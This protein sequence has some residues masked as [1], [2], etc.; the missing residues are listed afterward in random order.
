MTR[1]ADNLLSFV[2]DGYVLAVV[3]KYTF[4]AKL[5]VGVGRNQTDTNYTVDEAM[6]MSARRWLC[7]IEKRRSWR[8]GEHI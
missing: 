6:M 8:S 1:D 3:C 5:G 7:P 2:E 4:S